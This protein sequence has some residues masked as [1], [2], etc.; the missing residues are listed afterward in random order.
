MMDIKFI[1]DN[2]ALVKK[3]NKNKGYNID[4]DRLLDLDKRRRELL[5]E[6]ETLRAEQKSHN[7]AI[8]KAAPAEKKKMTDKMK[9]LAEK[10]DT[11]KPELEKVEKEFTD[12]MWRVPQIADPETPIGKDSDDNKVVYKKGELP[13]FNFK[14]KSH[15]ELARDL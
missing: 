5:Q 6:T 7:D 14:P 3:N 12:L 13:K 8:A 15:I 11:F 2:V 4:I 10:I 1:R 9:K